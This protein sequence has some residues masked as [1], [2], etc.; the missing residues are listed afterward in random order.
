MG[1]YVGIDA[2]KASTAICVEVDDV[3]YFFN[4]TTHFGNFSGWMKLVEPVT[5]YRLLIYDYPKDYSESEKYKLFA[6][7]DT[8]GKIISDLLQH[9]TNTSTFIGM[10]SYSQ[11]SDAGHLIDLVTLG[12]FIRFK[13]LSVNSNMTLYAPMQLKKECCKITYNI[14]DKKKIW[15]DPNGL[16]GGSFKKPDMLRAMLD[17]SPNSKLSQ[18]LSPDKDHLLSLKAI[19]KPIDDLVDAWW[20]K[21]I[22]KNSSKSKIL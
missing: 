8:A 6:Y 3:D 16:A 2:S 7:E 13:V 1:T 17:Y 5:T 4:Y 21:E 10:E 19:P 9:I 11:S 20:A 14:Q 12:T 18:I 22:A 15:R